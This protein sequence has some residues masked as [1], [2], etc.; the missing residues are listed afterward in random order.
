VSGRVVLITGA[1]SGIGAATARAFGARGDRLVLVARRADRLG[2]VAAELPQALVVPAD[3]TD[4]TA[5][6]R[7]V[8]AASA[9]YGR[10]DVLVNNAGIGRYGWVDELDPQDVRDEVATNLIAPVLMTRA[11][12]PVMRR[13]GGGV[14]VNVSSVAGLLAVP[15]TSVYNATKFGLRGLTEALRRELAPQGIAVCGIYPSTVEGTEFRRGRRPGTGYLMPRRLRL[16]TEQVARAIVALADR[17]RRM[18]VM[19]RI[20][21]VA[22]VLNALAPGLLDF[23]AARAVRRLRP[24]V[25]VGSS[26]VDR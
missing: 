12:V 4:L 1:S 17:P 16:T 3:L 8:E 26:A 25:C 13:G 9:R 20:F 21:W 18:V 14:V 23:L 19:P 5:P 11:A 7:V 6:A 15:T 10:I 2:E 22:V 24:E